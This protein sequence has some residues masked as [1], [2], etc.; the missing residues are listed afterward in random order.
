[1]SDK[2]AK[3]GAMAFSSVIDTPRTAV[4]DGAIVTLT[5]GSR[6]TVTGTSYLTSLTTDEGST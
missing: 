3:A 2:Y 1:M 6:W 4:N 5:N